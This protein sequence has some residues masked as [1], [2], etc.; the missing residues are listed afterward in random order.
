MES[1][2]DEQANKYSQIKIM[3]SLGLKLETLSIMLITQVL[4]YEEDIFTVKFPIL[5]H[6]LILKASF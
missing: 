4:S 5:V 1:K 3:P 6:F 2:R